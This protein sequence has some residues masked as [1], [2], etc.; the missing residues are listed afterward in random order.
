MLDGRNDDF[1]QLSLLS[2][3]GAG[4]FVR[5]MGFSRFH[6]RRRIVY[7]ILLR[8]LQRFYHTTDELGHQSKTILH[9]DR[10]VHYSLRIMAAHVSQS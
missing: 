9:H 8:L 3:G 2:Q 7:M 5:F 1:G 6:A 4:D 10:S